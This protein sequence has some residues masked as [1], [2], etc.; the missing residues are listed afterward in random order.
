MRAPWIFVGFALV[1]MFAGANLAL[2]AVVNT[3]L[4]AFVV[5][6]LRASFVSYLGGT[7]CC[8]VA[9]LITRQTLAIAP[10]GFIT[11]WWWWTGGLYGLVYLAIVVWLA[12]RLG[13]APVFALVVAGQMIAA[14]AF[15]RLGLSG[16]PA[17]PIDAA[18][19]A[20][21]ASLILGVVLLRR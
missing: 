19:I 11:N 1:G 6:P 5:T 7:V 9:L 14:L 16:L 10:A 21:V 12:P 3:Q 8:I 13:T 17:V 15:D 20:G 18:K 2:Q 4:R